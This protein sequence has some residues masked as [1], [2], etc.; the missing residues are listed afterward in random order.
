MDRPLFR[1][2]PA[3]SR[4]IT[5]IRALAAVAMGVVAVFGWT[6]ATASPTGFC[7]D[8]AHRF[9]T[10]SLFAPALDRSKK[11]LVYVPPGYDCATSRRYPVFYFNDGHDLFDGTPAAPDL[12]PAVAAD[13]A[14]REAWYGSWRLDDQLD[15]AIAHQDLPPLI[16][17]GIASDDG[18]RS[19]DLAPVP[20]SG[21]AEGRGTQYG[22]F[23]ARAVVRAVDRRFRTTADR[24][25]R[26]IGGA[27]L[28]GISALQIGLAHPDRFGMVLALSPVLGDSAIADYLTTA[29]AVADHARRAGFLIDFDDDPAGGSGMRWLASVVARAAS[30]ERQTTLI[31]TPGSRHAIGSWATRVMPALGQLLEA[32]CSG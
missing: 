26:G 29:W 30:A 24:R 21:S 8:M 16:V 10:F 4:K 9:E 23:V 14:A 18:M 25:C 6:L 19:R 28:G 27:S 7:P 2:S 32:S 11:I 31:R 3:T 1:A 5:T 17:V 22:D 13:I 20:W 15:R 12:E